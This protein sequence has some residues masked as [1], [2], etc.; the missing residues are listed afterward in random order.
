MPTLPQLIPASQPGMLTAWA[1]NFAGQTATMMATSDGRLLMFPLSPMQGAFPGKITASTML[2]GFSGSPGGIT[3]PS[4]ASFFAS[5]GLYSL[6]NSTQLSLINS[7]ST[8]I[9]TTASQ[10]QALVQGPRQLQF[11]SSQWSV[12][13]VLSEAPYWVGLHCQSSGVSFSLWHS[14]GPFMDS[15][16]SG[17]IGVG[18]T[19]S[20]ASRPFPGL[21]VF[22]TTFSSGMPGS[23]AFSQLRQDDPLADGIPTVLINNIGA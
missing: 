9:A 7:A 19:D 8:L 10:L 15:R 22:S 1:N 4:V 11:V 14:G 3:S 16:F 13:P 5:V 23:V 17:H 6:A 20:S 18:N 2:F 21:G 12:P